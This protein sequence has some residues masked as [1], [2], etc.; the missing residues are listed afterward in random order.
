MRQ[1]HIITPDGKGGQTLI[2]P[3]PVN[4][5][6]AEAAKLDKG[7]LYI[8]GHRPRKLGSQ[9]QTAYFA[10]VAKENA[11]MIERAKKEIEAQKPKPG[12]PAPTTPPPT[13]SKEALKAKEAAKAEAQ[14]Q[15]NK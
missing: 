13:P 7:L 3:G 14:K 11:A 8:D 9:S 10:L 15:L 5:I 2:G 12:K 4:K 6:R 1:A